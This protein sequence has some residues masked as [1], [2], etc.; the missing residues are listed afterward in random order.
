MFAEE[1]LADAVDA[2]VRQARAFAPAT[3]PAADG[4]TH[5]VAADACMHVEIVFASP[6]LRRAGN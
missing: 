3:P 5:T 2:A 6:L 1:R 4:L